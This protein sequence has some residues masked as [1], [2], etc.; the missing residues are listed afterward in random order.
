[1]KQ[2]E[3]FEATLVRIASERQQ[4]SDGIM[5]NVPVEKTLVLRA[6]NE[7][8]LALMVAF[9]AFDGWRVKE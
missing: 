2:P 6:Y 5:R 8:D 7:S 1:M 4:N 9:A 3:H